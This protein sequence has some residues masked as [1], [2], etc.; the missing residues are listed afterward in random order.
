MHGHDALD[1]TLS[2]ER[3]TSP[4]YRE[5]VRLARAIPGYRHSAAEE[6]ERHSVPITVAALPVAERLLR[7]VAGWRGAVVHAQGIALYGTETFW[8]L[9]MLSCYRRRERSRLGALYCWGLPERELGRLPC[10]LVDAAL[11]WATPPDDYADPRLLPNLLE[12]QASETFAALCPAYDGE[13][14]EQAARTW[15]GGDPAARSALERLLGDVDVDLGDG[16]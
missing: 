1:C 4:Y 8:L 15:L 13:S 5:A 14:I 11:P 16:P 6:P 7:L 2:F 10:R 9:H 3:S 12:A